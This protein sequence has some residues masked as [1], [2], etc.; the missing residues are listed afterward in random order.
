[1]HAGLRSGRLPILTCEH[2][3]SAIFKLPRLSPPEQDGQRAYKRKIGALY[4]NHYCSWKAINTTYSACVSVAL[5]IQH[6]KHMPRIVSSSVACLVL[7]Y[8]STLFHKRHDFR[9]K[10]VI[11][12]KMCVLNLST[13]FVR[14]T[15]RF[16]KKSDRYHKC[17]RR[18]SRKVPV[19]LVRF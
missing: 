8:S 4:S 9:W 5:V 13:N 11:E 17:T 16:K 12:Y 1:M 10:K 14:K 3:T 2:V 18:P 19:I 15:S 7:P 6:A